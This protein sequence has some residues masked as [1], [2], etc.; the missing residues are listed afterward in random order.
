MEDSMRRGPS[1]GQQIKA[2]QSK[3]TERKNRH[4]RQRQREIERRVVLT[5]PSC[6]QRKNPVDNVLVCFVYTTRRPLPTS[7]VNAHT[8]RRKERTRRSSFDARVLCSRPDAGGESKG[9]TF[10]WLPEPGALHPNA[11]PQCTYAQASLARA[12]SIQRVALPRQCVRWRCAHC[13][14]TKRRYSLL[15]SPPSERRTRKKEKKS[16]EKK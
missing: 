14:L 8:C 7:F 16:K 9:T 15:P 1:N 10:R 2:K 12:P 11:R 4:N 5:K 13:P 6:R 3:V